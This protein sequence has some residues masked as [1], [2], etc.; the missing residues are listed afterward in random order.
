MRSRNVIAMSPRMVQNYAEVSCTSYRG[1]AMPTA[2]NYLP[3]TQFRL[4]KPCKDFRAPVTTGLVDK[5]LLDEG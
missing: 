3:G 5:W 4:A 1:Q 2:K